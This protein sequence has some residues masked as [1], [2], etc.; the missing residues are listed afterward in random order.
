MFL[1]KA[2]PRPRFL[3]RAIPKEVRALLTPSGGGRL[4]LRGGTR[5]KARPTSRRGRR[6]AHRRAIVRA[7]RCLERKLNAMT[8]IYPPGQG[9]RR[10]EFSSPHIDSWG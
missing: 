10:N 6:L 7:E 5:I 1:S 2:V 4:G 3:R 8:T 9:N